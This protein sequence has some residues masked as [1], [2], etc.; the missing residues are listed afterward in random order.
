MEPGSRM[1]EGQRQEIFSSNL[2]VMSFLCDAICFH[3]KLFADNAPVP[4]ECK[5]WSVV[6]GAIA[7]AHAD[8]FY[9]GRIRAPI[10]QVLGEQVVGVY[11]LLKSFLGFDLDDDPMSVHML[12][13]CVGSDSEFVIFRQVFILHDK[14][15]LSIIHSDNCQQI[16]VFFQVVVMRDAA[17]G[18]RKKCC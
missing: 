1:E 16:F 11:N 5:T 10:E 9:D 4:R 12:P 15:L 7:H 2:N 17:C 14:F 6:W 8:S 18:S 13:L 3:E